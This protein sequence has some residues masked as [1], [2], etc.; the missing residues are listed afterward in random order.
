MIALI[1]SSMFLISA[2]SSYQKDV[3][4][5]SIEVKENSVPTTIEAGEFDNAG[6][7]LIITYEDGTSEEMPVTSELIPE[8][9][10]NY[11]TTPGTYKITI[12]FKGFETELT[13]TIVENIT[14]FTVKFYDAYG[15]LISIQNVEDGEDAIEPTELESSVSGY[16]LVGWDRTFTNVT[17]NIHVYGIYEKIEV[18]DEINFL[19][20]L[21]SAENYFKTH[22][23][24][25]LKKYWHNSL[26]E[27]FTKT[28]YHYDDTTKVAESQ[29]ISTSSDLYTVYN[30]F[31]DKVEFY[32]KHIQDG[33]CV[34]E[35][36]TDWTESFNEL[37]VEEKLKVV[38]FAGDNICFVDEY[39]SNYE[40]IE[41]AWTLS[42]NKNIYKCIISISEGSD[43]YTKE[44]IYTYDDEKILSIDIN[45][46]DNTNTESTS[47]IWQKNI[48]IDYTTYD[49]DQ[50]L[51]PENVKTSNS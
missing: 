36:Y 32:H 3:N 26:S 22:N 47:L 42:Q 15:K 12:L 43:D 9:Y 29:K 23:H 48:N 49:F 33:E 18:L 35:A 19:N 38:L 37:G 24:Y 51:I 50:T 31:S 1:I 2:C 4:I 40:N 28:T 11:L 21:E 7:T 20:K 25:S 17:E 39:I 34:D 8:N 41:Y 10:H 14:T 5:T 46:Y 13:L 6:I 27:E 16:E 44:I 45:F 30:Y